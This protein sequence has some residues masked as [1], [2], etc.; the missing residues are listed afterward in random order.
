MAEVSGCSTSTRRGSVRLASGR[1]VTC[2]KGSSA[3][4]VT[5]STTPTGTP[6]GYRKSRPEVCSTSPIWM[7]ASL[8]WKRSS[9]S[10]GLGVPKASACRPLRRTLTGTLITGSVISVISLLNG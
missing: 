3:G 2:A 6:G 10:A 1:T 7:S 4:S 8:L 5:S 9:I